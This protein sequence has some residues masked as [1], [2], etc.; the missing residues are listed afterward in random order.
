MNM[1]NLSSVFAKLFKLLF[2]KY[3]I[4]HILLKNHTLTLNDLRSFIVIMRNALLENR[5][6]CYHIIPNYKE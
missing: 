3:T 6:Y 1:P 5:L 4:L 2:Q